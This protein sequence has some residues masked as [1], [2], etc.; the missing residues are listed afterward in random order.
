MSFNKIDE[1]TLRIIYTLCIVILIFP[2]FPVVL[3]LSVSVNAINYLCAYIPFCVQHQ[4]YGI[5]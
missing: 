5:C 4:S 1:I 3:T 2:S